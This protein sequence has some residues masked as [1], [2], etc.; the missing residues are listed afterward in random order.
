MNRTIKLSWLLAVIF[1]LNV[2]SVSAQTKEDILSGTADI[3][4]LGMD[5]SQVKFIGTASQFGDAGEITNETM[6]TRYFPGWNQLFI[7]EQKKYDVAKVVHRSETTLHY[8]IDI[9]EKANSAIGK[10]DFFSNSPDEFLS[11]DATKVE[12]LVKKYNFQ[13]KKGVG[14]MFFIEGMSKG[15][16]QASAWVVYVDMNSKKVLMSQH[17]LGKAGGFGFKNY[18]AKAFYNILKDSDYKDKSWK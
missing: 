15:K 13:G 12:A 9:T 7:N 16:D 5:F 18:W 8:A 1:F 4:W 2:K 6:K 3:T 17:I 10:K 14:L 11:L